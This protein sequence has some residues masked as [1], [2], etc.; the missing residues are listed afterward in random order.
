MEKIIDVAQCI[1]HEYKKQ[2]G[3][4]IDEMKLHKLLYFAQRESFAIKNEP[5]FEGVFE[6][7][8]YGPVCR[9]V[10]KA[11]SKSGIHGASSKISN[12][13]RYIINN[14]I[15][16]YGSLASWKLSE[17]S[18][19]EQSWKNSRIGLEE[20]K[21]GNREL[22]LEDIRM[23]AQK[24]QPYNCEWNMP[25]DE[26]EDDENLDFMCG[27]SDD[28]LT[29]RFERAVYMENEV[30][31]SKGVPIAKYD[32]EK[33]AAYLEYPDGSRKYADE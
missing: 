32:I 14:V 10:R 12:E 23:D 17:L 31:R 9:E 18:H 11:F 30:K 8:K 25:Q 24:V 13:S 33:R 16:E 19:K 15:Q 27:I 20:G 21:S 2:T 28:E 26:I 4:K 22:K 6:G 3:E 5:L 29:L 1:F 7:W